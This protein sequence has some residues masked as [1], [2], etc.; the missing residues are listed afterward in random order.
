MGAIAL[1]PSCSKLLDLVCE[2]AFDHHR[3]IKLELTRPE[4]IH[5]ALISDSSHSKQNDETSTMP[6]TLLIGMLTVA[7]VDINRFFPAQHTKL[8]HKCSEIS[9]IALVIHK[10]LAWEYL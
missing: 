8:R 6:A 9:N 4:N 10:R 1:A 2:M 5:L 7:L 3:F